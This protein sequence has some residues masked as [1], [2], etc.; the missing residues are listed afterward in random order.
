MHLS[1]VF[2]YVRLVYTVIH[3]YA[4]VWVTALYTMTFLNFILDNM[5]LI[6]AKLTLKFNLY[7]Q[8]SS[9]AGTSILTLIAT[10][11]DSPRNGPPFRFQIIGGN[12]DTMFHVSPDGVLST[13]AILRRGAKEKHAL[14][15]QVRYNHKY[16]KWNQTRQNI[17]I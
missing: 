3:S 13:I 5:P 6:F 9:P 7:P 17:M 16:T 4:M 10:D 15:I 1:S 8:D 12:E 14:K 11:K 2:T